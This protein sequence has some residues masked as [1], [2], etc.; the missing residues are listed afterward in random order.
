LGFALACSAPASAGTLLPA[1]NCGTVPGTNCLQFQDFTVYSLALLN[2]QAGAGPIGPGDPYA[3]STN[4]TALQNAL[5][6]G[7]GVNGAGSINSDIL[8]GGVVDNAYNTPSAQGGGIT[9]FVPGAGNQGAQ[10]ANIPGNT[11]GTWDI[12]VSALNQYLNGGSLNYFF[13]LNQT[14][15]QTTTYLNSPQ[16]ALGWMQVTLRDSTGQNGPV[17]FWLDGNA[18]NGQLGV[19][20]SGNCDP[21]QSVSQSIDPNAAILPNNPLHDEWAYIHGQ[22]CVSPA[23]GVVNFGACAKGDKVDSTVNQNLG[24]N[25]A[26]FGLY[27]AALQSALN[28]GLYDVLSID[29]RMAALTNG[30]EQLLIFAGNQVPQDVPEPLT[31]TLFGA[32][33]AGLGVWRRRSRKA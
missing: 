20:G 1:A 27:S 8:P 15:S 4:G 12:K 33:L 24:A 7:T 14:N 18:C 28:S 32:G 3:V 29:F 23:G 31:I 9:N 2:F 30:Y 5:V 19:P 11:S 17:S 16:D 6:V 25:D 22:I 26:S 10:G 13:N 21:S